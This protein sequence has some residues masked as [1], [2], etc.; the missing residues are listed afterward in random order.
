[1]ATAGVLLLV[2]TTAVACSSTNSS[3]GSGSGSSS[4]SGGSS[5]GGSKIP[6]SAFSD[7]TG[8]TSKSVRVG[9]V[10]TLAIG[11]LFKGALVG[12]EAYSDYVNS[13]GG[14]NGRTITVDSGDDGFSGVG[15]KQATQNAI[16]HDFALVGGFSLQ[17]NF[18]G[19]L[20]AKAP[21]VP[22]V[23]MVLDSA[24]NKLPNVYSAVPLNGG[25]E[26]GPLA[27]FKKKF[28]NDVDGVG[29][30]VSNV[31]SA[32]KDWAGEK[33]VMEHE[34]YKIVY[35]P[36]IPVTQTDF[37]A[38]VVAMKQAGVKILFI[39]QL[40]QNYASALLKN[41]VQQNFHPQVI[42]G[43]ASYSNA[44]I[45]NS[46]GA[47]AVNGA[48]VDQ[49]TSFFLGEDAL[50][51]PAVGL[52]NKWVQ[53]ASPGF[54]P[55]LFTLYGWLSAQLFSQALKNAG[56]DPTRGSLLQ[57]LSKVTTF[58]GDNIV[59]PSDPA[60]KTV[61]NCYLIGQVANGQ[62]QRLDDPPVTSSTNGYRCDGQYLT[63]PGS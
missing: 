21:G 15:N 22:D 52:F 54:K 24:T 41:L 62:Y 30:I 43:A 8:I 29:T 3:S 46:G 61:G 38:N 57:S 17:D 13:L 4:G 1:M 12:T 56:S 60:T 35:S 9:N 59:T 26:T 37:T 33:Y 45:P 44:L 50:V 23:T 18:G 47:S 63:P 10:S 7:H 34:G 6:S 20:L 51:I 16:D 19:A 39:D 40:P 53:I 32:E 27:Y 11:G 42:L 28:P 55:D 36:S 14:V 5:G 58:S 48:L 25:W 31:P 49:N 2:A